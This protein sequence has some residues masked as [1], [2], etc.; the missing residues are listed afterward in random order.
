MTLLV[1]RIIENFMSRNF[2]IFAVELFVVIFGVFIGIQVSNWNDAR[3]DRVRGQSYLERIAADL[4]ADIANYQ[5]RLKFWE[6]VSA[7]GTAGLDYANT[8]DV[9]GLTHWD[10]LLAFFQASQLAEFYTTQSTYEE[11]KSGG[12]LGLIA[13]LEIR[14]MLA[15]YY[16]S[17]D[18]PLLTERP[19]Y[20]EHVRGLI[21][22]HV[23]N[24]IWDE[25]YWS[26]GDTQELQD[27]ESP[28]EPGEAE[29]IIKVIGE[30]EQLMTELR[31][32][33]STMRVAR[34]FGSDR[35][36]L[37]EQL[38]DLVQMELGGPLVAPCCLLRYPSQTIC[39][40]HR[41]AR[42]SGLLSRQ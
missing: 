12:E 20:R 30:D 23:Q 27:C 24:Y 6:G 8:G 19:A 17:A 36:V 5:Q 1:R 14:E 35:L 39:F 11:L 7:Y 32:W 29:R 34:L 15:R 37:A 9:E 33:M 26:D 31:Y 38:Q 3:L 10:I 16:T 2:S 22:L 21:P 28:I 41:R 25:C 13:N 42:Q 18:N 4:D 40:P